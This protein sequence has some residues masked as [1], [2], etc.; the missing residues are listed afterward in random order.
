MIRT[1]RTVSVLVGLIANLIP[2][3]GVLYWGWDTFQLLMLYWMETVIIAFWTIRRIAHLPDNQLGTIKVNGKTKAATHNTLCGFF[4]LHAGLFI[5]VHLVFL[6][7]LFS[8]EWL[9]KVH[10]FGSFM[11]ELFVANGI[12]IAL[13]FMFVASWISYVVRTPPAYPRKMERGLYPKK[14]VAPAPEA[15]GNSVGAIV[16][17]LYVRIVIMQIAI[18]AGAIFAQSYGSI[19]PLLIVI[20]FKTLADMAA[21]IRGSSAALKGATWSSGNTSVTS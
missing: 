15:E 11:N 16:G 8:G 21:S 6:W 20:G 17:G 9:K 19:A 2:L 7:V 4:T 1:I 3:Y 5:F 13:L 14:K 10:G 12:W 18:I